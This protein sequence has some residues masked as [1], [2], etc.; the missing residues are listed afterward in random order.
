[1]NFDCLADYLSRI[2]NSCI[3]R[4]NRRIHC[5]L[6][7]SKHFI[8]LKNARSFAGILLSWL[9]LLAC[10]APQTNQLLLERP[11]D[12]PE[13]ALVAE[14]PFFPQ[15]QFHCGPATLAMVINFYGN[16]TTPTEL[17]KDVFTPDLKGSLQIEMQ[18]A[19][20]KR[21]MLAYVLTPELVYLLAEVSVGHPVIVLQNLA[22][23]WYPVWHYAVVIGYDLNKK[24]ITLH[25][26]LNSN[27]KVS[28]NTFEHTWQRANNWALVVLPSD[29]LPNDRNLVSVLQAAV[30]LEQVGQIEHA[31]LAYQAIA[32]RWPSSYVAI[33]GIANTYLSL[34]QPDKATSSYLRAAEIQPLQ[35]DIYNNLAYSLHAQSCHDASLKSIQCAITLEPNNLEYRDSLRE[36]GQS[37]S[38]IDSITCPM[39]NCP[40]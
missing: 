30:D 36:L 38:E 2:Y 10:V 15:E 8:W 4:S 11:Q 31:N 17:A 3:S 12:L 40:K 5:N 33:M 16:K 13:Q 14:V 26:G 39:I 23:K 32:K 20:R 25:T 24:T 1:M 19:V 28:M 21:G 9:T 35:A 27:Y 29:T 18:A 34:Q 22:I 7:L 37:K 6:T